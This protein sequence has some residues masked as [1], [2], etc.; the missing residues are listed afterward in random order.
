MKKRILS[1]VSTV[2]ALTMLTSCGKTVTDQNAKTTTGKENSISSEKEK[3]SKNKITIADAFAEE[4]KFRYIDGYGD[5]SADE[6]ILNNVANKLANQYLADKDMNNAEKKDFLEDFTSDFFYDVHMVYEPK[7]MLSN[8]DVVNIAISTTEDFKE[9]YGFGASDIDVTVSGL[10]DKDSV[11][12]V[13]IFNPENIM[14][15]YTSGVSRCWELSHIKYPIIF[16]LSDN[17]REYADYPEGKTVKVTGIEVL[18]DR[19]QKYTKESDIYN[20][21]YQEYNIIPES[22]TG[23]FIA[24]QEMTERVCE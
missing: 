7:E 22:L 5:V 8:G 18:H 1:I 2:L 3:K 4:I 13:D 6:D 17:Y 19:A 16:V 20:Y 10:V 15:Y 21:L 11:E 12:T 23:E 14:A 9:K 24:T